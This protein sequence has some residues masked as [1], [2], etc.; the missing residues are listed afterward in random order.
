MIE[1]RAYSATM[2]ASKAFEMDGGKGM[3]GAQ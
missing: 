1:S 3:G 2:A